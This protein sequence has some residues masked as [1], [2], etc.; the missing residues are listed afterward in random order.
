[1]GLIIYLLI[2]TVIISIAVEIG[3]E[4][5]RNKE[6]KALMEVLEETK[7]LANRGLDK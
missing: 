7:A 3:Y 6:I 4:T 5:R 1:M 2:Q